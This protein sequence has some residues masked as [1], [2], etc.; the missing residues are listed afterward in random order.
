MSLFT[1]I[2][3]VITFS[4]FIPRYYLKNNSVSSQL[5]PDEAAQ[6]SGALLFL[7]TMTIKLANQSKRWQQFEPMEWSKILHVNRTWKHDRL[8]HVRRTSN[9]LMAWRACLKRISVTSQFGSTLFTWI[10]NWSSWIMVNYSCTRVEKRISPR[11][12]AFE[13]FNLLTRS[14]EIGDIIPW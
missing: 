3:W 7:F 4:F 10:K 14:Y 11:E 6:V 12:W 2:K 13:L 8:D 1:R 5:L 9:W